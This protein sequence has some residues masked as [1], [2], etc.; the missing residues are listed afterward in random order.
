[1]PAHPPPD[2]AETC[3]G[4][5]SVLAPVPGAPSAHPR[6]SPSCTRLFEVTVGGLREEAGADPGTAA[7]LRRAEAA[8]AAQHRVPGESDPRPPAVWR[9]TIAD[10]AADLDVIDLVVLIDAWARAVEEDWSAA[11]TV[12]AQPPYFQ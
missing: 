5:G 2:P 6:A 11:V 10:V 12:G 1:M 3:P 7:V 8:Y 4:C 9:T